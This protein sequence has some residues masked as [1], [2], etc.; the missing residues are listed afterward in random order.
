MVQPSFR[1]ALV[2]A[3]GATPLLQTGRGAA[4][5]AAIALSAV[6]MPAEAE[7]GMTSAANALPENRFARNRHA[8][9]RGL[10][11]GNASWQVRISFDVG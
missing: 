4:S 3:V 9:R 2:T 7:H 6:T 5:R 11:N 1:S 10:D 8:R